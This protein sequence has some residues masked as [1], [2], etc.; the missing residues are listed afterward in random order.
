MLC[1]CDSAATSVDVLIK[2]S[3]VGL[4]SPNKGVGEG[5]SHPLNF[6]TRQG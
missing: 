4:I 5:G 2:V 6:Y 3:V 1:I